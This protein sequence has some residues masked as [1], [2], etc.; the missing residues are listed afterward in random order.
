MKNLVYCSKVFF[1]F[2]LILVVPVL[3]Q[4]NIST[5]LCYQGYLTDNLGVP[6]DGTKTMNFSV[7]NDPVSG[8]KFWESGQQNI[9]IQK[10]VFDVILI[11]PKSIFQHNIPSMFLDISVQGEVLTPRQTIY[12]V[13]YALFAYNT[14]LDTLENQLVLKHDVKLINNDAIW[15]YNPGETNPEL[16]IT[17]E[18][19]TSYN[20]DNTFGMNISLGGKALDI[21]NSDQSV[22]IATIRLKNDCGYIELRDASNQITIK[23]DGS[24][25]DILYR[26]SVAPF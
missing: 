11:V 3:A 23:L 15:F 20:D 10:G 24:T 25:G 26:G 18:R 6:V 5:N 14:E 17:P 9:I 22:K 12:S 21:Y 13:P 7:Y 8:T 4:D 2:L 19:I 1:C 16:V